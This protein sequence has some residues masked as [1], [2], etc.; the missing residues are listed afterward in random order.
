MA[1]YSACMCVVRKCRHLRFSHTVARA[2]ISTESRRTAFPACAIKTLFLQSSVV[3]STQ[4]PGGS[5]GLADDILKEKLAASRP[6]DD[7][8][9]ED[10]DASAKDQGSE[11]KSGRW[12]GKN[13]WKLGLVFL[14][15]W[16][17][18]SGGMLIYIWG[19]EA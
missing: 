19:E 6:T 8:T 15:G 3:Y 16:S 1:A 7:K 12:T 11:K 2:L 10:G 13:A 17:V 14:S 4:A 9:T 18:V 5:K